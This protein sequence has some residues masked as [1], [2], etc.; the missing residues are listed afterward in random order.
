M[1]DLA[2][3][4]FL[5]H[6]RRI[7]R[8]FCAQTQQL[9]RFKG[10]PCAAPFTDGRT[11]RQPRQQSGAFHLGGGDGAG[12]FGLGTHNGQRRTGKAVHGHFGQAVQRIQRADRHGVQLRH[13]RGFAFDGGIKRGADF[14]ELLA[15]DR[16]VGHI[17]HA[18][19]D[20]FLHH[21]FEM[22]HILK[23][24]T[25]QR[26]GIARL[27]RIGV[28]L[29]RSRHA[30]IRILRQRHGSDLDIGHG[31][32]AFTRTAAIVKQ[33]LIHHQIGGQR[34]QGC[35]AD[36]RPDLGQPVLAC[37]F[38]AEGGGAQLC[39]GGAAVGGQHGRGHLIRHG[40][41][42]QNRRPQRQTL[43]DL[44]VCADF[45]GVGGFDR[46]RGIGGAEPGNDVRL[47]QVTGHHTA[48]EIR[49]AAG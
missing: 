4:G 31:K 13:R 3:R 45:F 18:A 41:I 29:Q 25:V 38:R 24:D 42:G 2:G 1:P 46:L 10:Q 36:L 37:C 39:L 49:H 40:V 7:K 30:V 28:E 19:F 16:Q 8:G 17:G 33:H 6:G 23:R 27:D 11:R 34:P 15:Q 5:G 20:P 48:A 43:D 14:K 9:I 21:P 32:G 22:R 26:G 44:A 35:Q 47:H 12:L